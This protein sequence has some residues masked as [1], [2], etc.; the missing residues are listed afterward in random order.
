[1]YDGLKSILGIRIQIWLDQNLFGKNQIFERAFPVR[2]TIFSAFQQ[3]STKIRE[4]Q[5]LSFTSTDALPVL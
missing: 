4:S 1:M 3:S 5:N 2:S